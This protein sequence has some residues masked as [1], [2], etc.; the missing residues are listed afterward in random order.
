MKIKIDA[1]ILTKALEAVIRVIPNKSALP[2]LEC[3]LLRAE[4]DIITVIGSGDNRM[5]ITL[6]DGFQVEEPGVVA[7]TA[8][9]FLAM[10]KKTNSGDTITLEE[11]DDKLFVKKKGMRCS[12]QILSKDESEYPNPAEMSDCKRI[13][14]PFDELKKNIQNT[15]FAVG[16]ESE[17]LSGKG[18]GYTLKINGN[19][20]RGYAVDGYR[21]AVRETE[22]DEKNLDEVE[23]RIPKSA[24]SEIVK[25]G[26]K[27]TGEKKIEISYNTKFVL[28]QMDKTKLFV[29][30]LSDKAFDIDA[31]VIDPDNHF[32][33]KTSEL[34]DAV[35]SLMPFVG[36]TYKTLTARLDGNDET[37]TLSIST[38]IGEGETTVDVKN[39][40]SNVPLRSI[41][42]GF[43]INYFM[44]AVSAVEGETFDFILN[45]NVAPVKFTD[46]NAYYIT[47]PVRLHA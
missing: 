3:V 29:R 17:L 33:V 23:L 38:P 46:G 36:G 34:Y 9:T 5:E 26:G 18:L 44:D 43:N 42:I 10:M 13:T 31:L 7:V 1:T 39:L 22:L 4:P 16:I 28:F 35:D 25:M 32:E 14:I 47:L 41:T 2:I 15:L 6:N 19:R 21:V 11:K 27:E 30:M 40:N 37:L 12:L 8:K 20:M 24:L 45:S